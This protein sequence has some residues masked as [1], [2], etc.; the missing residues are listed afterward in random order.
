V[1]DGLV[2]R[3]LFII[4]VLFFGQTT[5][6]KL[7]TLGSCLDFFVCLGNIS[8]SGA[9]PGKQ[10][11]NYFSANRNWHLVSI[12]LVNSNMNTTGT[13]TFTSEWVLFGRLIITM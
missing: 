12:A 10:T 6:K 4:F 1:L 7:V 2:T 5:I 9:W 13:K 11:A 3:N 8:F